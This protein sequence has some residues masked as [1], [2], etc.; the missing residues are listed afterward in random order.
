MNI[1]KLHGSLMKSYFLVNGGLY[2]HMV[3]IIDDPKGILLFLGGTVNTK[4]W[5]IT[6]NLAFEVK[7]INSVVSRI[8]T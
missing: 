7:Y 1:M 6:Q 5:K 3:G 8:F 4:M 2:A